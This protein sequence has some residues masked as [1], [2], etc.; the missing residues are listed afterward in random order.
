M[1]QAGQRSA[2]LNTARKNG[3]PAGYPG[4]QNDALMIAGITSTQVATTEEWSFPSTPVVQEGQLWIKTATGASSVMKG[5]QAQGTGSWATGGSL[6][7]AR[8]LASGSGTQTSSNC[9]SG[10]T[11]AA[12][13]QV[14]NYD[15]TSWTEVAE[16]NTDRY[17]TSAAGA[18]NTAS[19]VFSGYTTTN[20]ANTE[21]WNGTAWTEVND[22]NTARHYGG[23]AGIQGDA[24]MFGGTTG[25]ATATTEKWNGS[26]W[27]EVSDLNTGRVA[28]A[29]TGQSGSSAIGIGGE[30]GEANVETWNGTAWTEVNDLNEGRE[31]LGA[32]GNA[33]VALAFGGSDPGAR[34]NSTEFW[35]GSSW[36][37]VNNLGT[38]RTNVEGSGTGLLGLAFSG[39]TGSVS[40]ATEEWT[41]P[42]VTKTIGTD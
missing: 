23:G 12:V 38:T 24:L 18:N 22:L 35:N 40:N 19:L 41:V 37:E 5:S 33:S 6:N 4:G 7:T 9:I 34:V 1:V 13:A 36:T 8:R 26:S 2:D 11:T 20:V 10:Y 31:H 39:N 32:S 30:N 25:S 16:L 28:L 27:T 14:E 42:F 15:G 17:G 29:G 21:S 3:T